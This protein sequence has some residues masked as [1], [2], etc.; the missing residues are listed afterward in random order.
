MLPSSLGQP[1][2]AQD[3]EALHDLPLSTPSRSLLGGTQP[4]NIVSRSIVG[5]HLLFFRPHLRTV[6]T[7][8]VVPV[9]L[10]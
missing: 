10:R 1:T 8:L 6:T 9:T 2:V 4:E 3:E 7:S 5:Y